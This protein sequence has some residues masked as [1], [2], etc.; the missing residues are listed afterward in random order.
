MTVL[1]ESKRDNNIN[2]KKDEVIG[3]FSYARSSNILVLTKPRF[4]AS[5]IEG[6]TS[7]FE[8]VAKG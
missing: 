2:N 7:Q 4:L 1:S 5:Y 8:F 6:A 3:L